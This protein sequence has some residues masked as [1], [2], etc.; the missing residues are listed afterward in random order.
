MASTVAS[1]SRSARVPDLDVSALSPTEYAILPGYVVG[2]QAARSGKEGHIEE[3]DLLRFLRDECNIGVDQEV[4]IFSLLERYPY[5]L[6]TG[7]VYAVLRLA[8]HAQ[9]G[10]PVS[11][12]AVFTQTVPVRV[13]AGSIQ[14]PPQHIAS[15]N[16][17]ASVNSNQSS[18]SS[19]SPTKSRAPPEVP[20]KPSRSI[21]L[22]PAPVATATVT[23]VPGNSLQAPLTPTPTKL[24]AMQEAANKSHAAPKANEVE[25]GRSP[26][27]PFRPTPVLWNAS[28]LPE[29]KVVAPIAVSA[30]E[31]GVHAFKESHASGGSTAPVAVKPKPVKPVPVSADASTSVT[32]GQ[33]PSRS[34]TAAS[35]RRERDRESSRSPVI[36]RGGREGSLHGSVADSEETSVAPGQRL[37]NL[38]SPPLPPRPLATDRAAPPLPPR[39]ANPLIQAGLA[40][41]REV[42]AKKDAL[43]PKT[44]SV[45]QSSAPVKRVE[46][47]LLDGKL[48][49]PGAPIPVTPAPPPPRRRPTA[50]AG[51]DPRRSISEI[52]SGLLRPA[53]SV[54]GKEPAGPQHAV[55]HASGS[56]PLKAPRAVSS[57]VVVPSA[58]RALTVHKPKASYGSV[59][60]LDGKGGLPSWLREQEELQRSS[61]GDVGLEA[62]RSASLP[63]VRNSSSG[64][65]SV[66]APPSVSSSRIEF[67]DQESEEEDDDDTR[68]GQASVAASIDRNNPFFMRSSRDADAHLP[69]TIGEP[70]TKLAVER[71]AA[72]AAILDG[73]APVGTQWN[74]P[75]SDGST[76]VAALGEG[77]RPLGRSKTL[78]SRAALNGMI[79]APPRRK[80]EEGPAAFDAGT[81]RGFG[82]QSRLDTPQS[83]GLRLNPTTKK[84]DVGIPPHVIL[85]REREKASRERGAL[86]Q[87]PPPAPPPPVRRPSA[88]D[89]I[90]SSS[91]GV[92]P[93]SPRD[94]EPPTGTSSGK[95]IRDRVSGFLGLNEGP[96]KGSRP[97]DHLK[98]DMVGVAEQHSWVAR[99]AEKA[100]GRPMHEGTVGLLEG[101]DDVAVLDEDAPDV[102]D[103]YEQKALDRPTPLYPSGQ[104]SASSTPQRSNSLRAA[105]VP[106]RPSELRR[107][108]SSARRSIAMMEG[109]F[110]DL[111]REDRVENARPEKASLQHVKNSSGS[112]GYE[113]PEP[114]ADGVKHGYAQLS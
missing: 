85:E 43:P 90:T 7:V 92:T 84:A 45:I 104:A 98:N 44:Y 71:A 112:S 22:A 55:P 108:S 23:P 39:G 8:S 54:D 101:G 10:D 11:P 33:V 73:T 17:K 78:Q 68:S 30:S 6:P 5:G 53:S 41:S 69:V 57:G 64:H 32:A 12:E 91:G 83:G 97:I 52:P 15:S 60:K 58:Q 62:P 37:A 88:V 114:D 111:S 25:H 93:L 86:H 29:S 31:A 82:K 1:S 65:A 28:A 40:A 70:L 51:Y 42:R 56:T 79:P 21:T 36:G 35:G 103:G 72:A 110:S 3:S 89:S 77:G 67:L 18:A 99:A 107:S 113:L 2:L 61:L 34:S 27:N 26:A 87:N 95:G 4:Q 63:R 102:D 13:G 66:D 109:P 9:R 47:R 105:P 74:R 59:G 48:P 100:K 49:P 19:S 38:G 16:A 76:S 80:L 96:A 75:V 20:S 14:P 24:S 94:G 50:S 106:P 46:P 81:Y